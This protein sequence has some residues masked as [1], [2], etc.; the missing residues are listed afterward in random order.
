MTDSPDSPTPVPGNTR[1]RYSI[2]LLL[3]TLAMITY[4]DRAVIGSSKA[5]IMGAVGRSPADFFYLLTAFQL[6]YALFEIPSGW[7]GDTFGPRKTLLRIVLW[8]TTFIGLTALAGYTIP[9]TEMIFLGFYGLILVQFLF[10]MG[11]AGA[12]PNISKALYNW[13]PLAQRGF[14][15][16]AVWMSARLMGGLTPMIWLLMTDPDIGGLSWRQGLGVLAL[17][18]LAWCAVFLWWFRNEPGEHRA[19]SD[20]EADLIAANRRP[21]VGH[22]GVPWKRIFTSRNMWCI[23]GMYFCLNFG[24][25]FFMYFLPG[26]F[27]E[28]FG[29]AGDSIG[30]KLGLAMLAGAPLLLGMPG[31]LVGGI[32]SDRWV[33]NTGDRK[34]G[35]RVYGMIGFFMCSVCY[36]V[37]VLSIKDLWVFAVFIGMA[38]FFNDLTMGS[39][40]ATCQDVGRKYAAVVSGFMNMIGNLGAALTNFVTGTI[41]ASYTTKIAIEGSDKFRFE[42]DPLGYQTC[43]MMYVVAYFVGT[44]FW[45]GIDASKPIVTED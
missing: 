13:F 42:V 28:N 19:V 15:Q 14:A 21:T 20:R 34:W 44:F 6:A 23:C 16:G 12:F 37:A 10:G 17:V 29:T 38:G 11:E 43:L 40:W 24:W 8:W 33:R 30:D 41:I 4:V 32:L 36:F 3:C 45:L 35:R 5:D 26:F 2:L 1:V 18:A 27:K 39:C 7:M 31:C 22:S 25:Y 9:G